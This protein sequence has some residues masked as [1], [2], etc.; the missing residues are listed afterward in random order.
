MLFFPALKQ[1]MTCHAIYWQK[2]RTKSK[3]IGDSYRLTAVCVCQRVNEVSRYKQIIFEI[4]SWNY[5]SY[6]NMKKVAAWSK[7]WVCSRSITGI[8]GSN[9]YLTILDEWWGLVEGG[10]RTKEHIRYTYKWM[11]VCTPLH[12]QGAMLCYWWRWRLV[13]WKRHLDGANQ[14]AV[15]E[16]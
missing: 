5:R 14:N 8:V 2:A 13:E 7:A 16:V 12:S 1:Y 10:W 4:C 6:Q 3:D 11:T 15:Y 9:P